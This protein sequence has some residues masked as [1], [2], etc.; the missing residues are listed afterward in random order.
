[1][2]AQKTLLAGWKGFS[3]RPDRQLSACVLEGVIGVAESAGIDITDILAAGG[4]S[5]ETVFKPGAVIRRSQGVAIVAAVAAATKDPSAAYRVGLGFPVAKLT[6]L[7]N[8]FRNAPSIEAMVGPIN[9]ALASVCHGVVSCWTTSQAVYLG[10]GFPGWTLSEEEPWQEAALGAAVAL[11]RERFGS[12][13]QPASFLVGHRRL[14]PVQTHLNGIPATVGTLDNAVVFKSSDIWLIPRTPTKFPQ[15][16]NSSRK[17][18]GTISNS[19]LQEIRLVIRGRLRLAQNANLSNIAEV[20]EVSSSTLKRRL[21]ESGT[22]LKQVVD[23]VRLEESR[24]LLSSTDISVTEIAF[25]LGYEH[26]PSFSRAFKRYAGLLP[27]EFRTD[28]QQTP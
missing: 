1:M 5:L 15:G 23:D 20:F 22:H 16:E 28:V 24:R 25:A 7:A 3:L 12:N 18:R 6:E 4:V 17:T 27:S 8:L 10:V 14:E 9:M 13:W 11:L 21:S 26:V 19:W 2:S